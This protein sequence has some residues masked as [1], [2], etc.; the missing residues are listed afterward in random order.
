MTKKEF[1]QPFVEIA[2]VT[3]REV[4]HGAK[5]PEGWVYEDHAQRWVP[6]LIGLHSACS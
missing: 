6:P 3:A 2:C 4:A 1:K 5:V